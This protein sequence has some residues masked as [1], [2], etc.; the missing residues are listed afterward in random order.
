[1]VSVLALSVVERGFKPW[2]WSYFTV[3]LS[4]IGGVMVSVLTLSVV[5]RESTIYH[6]QGEHA[7]HYATNVV[8]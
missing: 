7:N 4:H 8:M 1:M 6:T 3:L 2:S 5:D